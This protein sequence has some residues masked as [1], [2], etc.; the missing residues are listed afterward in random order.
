MFKIAGLV[1]GIG[2]WWYIVILLMIEIL[3]YRRDLKLW[4]LWYTHYHG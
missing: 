1:I 4:E 3:H 2:F